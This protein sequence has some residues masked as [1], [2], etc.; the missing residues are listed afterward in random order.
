MAT[1]KGSQEALMSGDACVPLRQERQENPTTTCTN[2]WNP[3]IESSSYCCLRKELGLCS[4]GFWAV[5]RPSSSSKT[6]STSNQP[7]EVA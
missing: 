2:F 6:L 1:R 7:L 4:V 5:K 3:Q